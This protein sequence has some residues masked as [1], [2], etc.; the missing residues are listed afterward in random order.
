MKNPVRAKGKRGAKKEAAEAPVPPP[1]RS[2]VCAE[3][4]NCDNVCK[5]FKLCGDCCKLAQKNHQIFC[6]THLPGDDSS[7]SSESS[8]LLMGRDKETKKRDRGHDGKSAAEVIRE[9]ADEHEVKMLTLVSPFFCSCPYTLLYH[10]ASSRGKGVGMI[11]S[12]TDIWLSTHIKFMR[13]VEEVREV[14]KTIIRLLSSSFLEVDA[15]ELLNL[16]KGP[17]NRWTELVVV[18]SLHGAAG[19]RAFRAKASAPEETP[20]ALKD[21]F[22]AAASAGARAKAEARR[23]DAA[24]GADGDDKAGGK[25]VG[26]WKAKR[27]ADKAAK[28]GG[29][30]K[31]SAAAA[32]SADASKAGK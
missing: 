16:I 18:R 13:D 14:T 31:D 3:C 11:Q 32:A 4:E 19:A 28:D 15:E 1:K 21:A 29:L 30:K 27:M 24:A 26:F 8:E 7:D 5:Q 23:A 20:S 25:K 12:K 22:T 10:E 2:D 9:L 6:E 17:L